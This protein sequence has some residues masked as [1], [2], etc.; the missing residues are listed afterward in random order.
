M[1]AN[2]STILSACITHVLLALYLQTLDC[3]IFEVSSTLSPFYCISIFPTYNDLILPLY[4]EKT[5]SYCVELHGICTC[6]SWSL[7][8]SIVMQQRGRFTVVLPQKSQRMNKILRRHAPGP[9]PRLQGWALSGCGGFE[10]SRF[11]KVF[12]ATRSSGGGPLHRWS[13][14]GV[15]WRTRE[16]RN[17]NIARSKGLIRQCFFQNRRD[18]SCPGA[19]CCSLFPILSMLAKSWTSLALSFHWSRIS[20]VMPSFVSWPACFP[21]EITNCWTARLVVFWTVQRLICWRGV[22]ISS[23]SRM[24]WREVH[25][26]SASTASTSWRAYELQKVM[27]R[28]SKCSCIHIYQQILDQVWIFWKGP[29]HWALWHPPGLHNPLINFLCCRQC[30]TPLRNLQNGCCGK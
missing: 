16:A 3:C 10:K 23:E 12:G 27:L 19:F 26:K 2:L 6:A 14:G 18:I 24:S 4:S 15:S 8:Q 17:M 7:I 28:F 30:N 25:V 22:L 20:F 21:K 13:R 5:L 29:L 1:H 9:S 11:V